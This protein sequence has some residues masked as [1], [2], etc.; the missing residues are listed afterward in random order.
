MQD[1]IFSGDIVNGDEASLTPRTGKPVPVAAKS[2]LVAITHTPAAATTSTQ[3]AATPEGTP[4]NTTR[5]RYAATLLG[6]LAV[7]LLAPATAHAVDNEPGP[8]T[9]TGC[10]YTDADGYPIPIDDGQDVFVDGKIVSCRNGKISTTTAPQRNGAA[11]RPGIG[12]GKLPVLTRL[13]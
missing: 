9:G 10:T 5:A 6:T 4:M 7:L 2:H 12:V 3:H 11:V 8:T 1:N 13:P